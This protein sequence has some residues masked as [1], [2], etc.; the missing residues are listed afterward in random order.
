MD[1]Q[2]TLPTRVGRTTYIYDN[3][4]RVTQTIRRRISKKPL[5]HRFYYAT[6]DQPVGF[7]SSDEPGV[8]YR[9]LYDPLGRRV[10][11]E[12]VNTETGETITRTVYSYVGHQLVAQQTTQSTDASRAQSG[13][14]LPREGEGYVW[15]LDPTTGEL[16]GQVTLNARGV[17][18]FEQ[19]STAAG[20]SDALTYRGRALK[21]RFSLIMS[22]LAG[23]PQELIDPDTG[24]ITG[25]A[26]QSLYGI[27][28]WYGE[29]VSPL[30]YAGQYLDSES[31]WAYNRFRFYDPSAGIY[32]AQ[33]PLGVFPSLGSAQAYVSHAAHEIDFLG[34]YKQVKDEELQK[35]LDTM[36]PNQK[37]TLG[38]D[39]A[40]Q[41]FDNEFNPDK[42]RGEPYYV[43]DQKRIP[44]LT[45]NNG[46]IVEAKFHRNLN[47][48]HWPQFEDALKEV[49]SKGDPNARYYVVVPPETHLS[50]PLRDEISANPDLVLVRLTESEI[51]GASGSRAIME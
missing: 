40:M 28:R 9:Y 6:N 50:K 25:H 24:V 31:G 21:S 45:L 32:N 7:T 11:K 38:E 16:T 36:T 42:P 30:L 41:L 48:G 47:R 3:A 34:L 19:L 51:A 43:G 44:D 2:G 1:F 15:T 8:G 13:S 10:A 20:R 39:I 4:G 26:R 46:S 33:D 14:P 17:N 5:V 18:A 35:H 27:R 49:R 37:G 12:Q 22:D 29:D 23:S